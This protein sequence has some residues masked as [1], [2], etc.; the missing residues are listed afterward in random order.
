MKRRL[1]HLRPLRTL[2]AT[3]RRLK[4]IS[5]CHLRGKA[6]SPFGK[7][8]C[9]EQRTPTL[10]GALEISM[11]LSPSDS[12]RAWQWFS[13][14]PTGISLPKNARLRPLPKIYSGP[15][16]NGD[17][18]LTS[19]IKRGC[20]TL[21]LSR[22]PSPPQSGST[23][24]RGLVARVMFRTW[25]LSTQHACGRAFTQQLIKQTP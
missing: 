11:K 19:W 13:L 10:R 7:A 24:S 18:R 3:K 14:G 16:T 8:F 23:S 5:M 9:L 22:T 15:T 6:A 12:S 1:K 20:R 2:S 21:S 4:M 17:T 25:M